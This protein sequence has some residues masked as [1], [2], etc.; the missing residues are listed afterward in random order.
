MDDEIET[1]IGKGAEIR[2]VPF[3]GSQRQILAPGYVAILSQLLR[4]VVKNGH[5]GARGGQDRALL[6]PA[7]GQTEHP[8]PWQG[9]KPV[10]GNSPVWG[11]YDRPFPPPRCCDH[12]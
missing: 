1:A 11:E 3:D 6:S 4:R 10:A 5:Y 2:H 12:V 7:A 8:R 9:R